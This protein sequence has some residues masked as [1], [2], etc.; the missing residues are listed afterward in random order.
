[1][2]LVKAMDAGP[3]FG[4]SEVSLS[5]DETKQDLADKLLEVGGAMLH[6]L[7]PGILDGSIVGLPQE[8]SR[9]TYDNLITKDD[10]V[11]DW[12]KSAQVIEREIRAF[13]DWP[14]SRTKF[15]GKEVVITKARV[16]DG[17]GQP[18]K[19]EARG[20]DITVFCGDRALIIEKLKPAGKNE[21]TSEAFLAGHRHLL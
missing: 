6:E 13:V 9:A 11:I 5:G 8:D 15:A 7:L 19:I 3:V 21:M 14:K 20:K 18:G 10:G 1:M 16:A 17:S 2:Q 12:S 4:Q